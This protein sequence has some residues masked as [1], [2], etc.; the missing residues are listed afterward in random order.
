MFWG[1]ASAAG[2]SWK[3]PDD[4]DD[5]A[6][7]ER[8]YPTPERDSGH[9]QPDW[10][11]VIKA[12]TAPRKHRRARLTRHQLWKEYRDQALAQGGSA[13]SYSRFCA[14]LKAR[15]K[16]GGEAGAQRPRIGGRQKRVELVPG[17]D[18]RQPSNCNPPA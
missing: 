7:R 14:R 1:R 5:E 3:L 17:A 12:L 6:L 13:Y 11:R 18:L 9:V 15:L 2:L 8:L 16:D 4:L 10:D